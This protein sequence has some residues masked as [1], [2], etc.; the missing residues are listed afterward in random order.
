MSWLLDTYL[1]ATRHRRQEDPEHDADRERAA[2]RAGFTLV[3]PMLKGA[4]ARHGLY[5][6]EAEAEA[7]RI[8]A[9]EAADE[10]QKPQRKRSSW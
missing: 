3:D 2:N 8:A 4:A 9:A 6:T 1:H 7:A 5:L 10:S